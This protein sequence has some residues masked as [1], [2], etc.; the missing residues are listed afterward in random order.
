MSDDLRTRI[1]GVLIAHPDQLTGE[2]CGSQGFTDVDQWAQHV[3]DAVIA[4]V[5]AA[6]SSSIK[7]YAQS[8][9]AAL[10]YHDPCWRETAYE[11]MEKLNGEADQIARYAMTYR[12]VSKDGNA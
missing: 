10:S 12:G 1:A 3:A 7:S 8:E 2:C 6:F 4:E 5:T 9:M 11:A